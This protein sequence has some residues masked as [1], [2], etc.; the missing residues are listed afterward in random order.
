MNSPVN[1]IVAHR[2][3]V[4]DD[5]LSQYIKCGGEYEKLEK[6][7][8]EK[9]YKNPDYI[10]WEGHTGYVFLGDTDLYVSRYNYTTESEQPYL[11]IRAE[12]GANPKGGSY[13]YAVIPYADKNTLEEYSK[14]PDVVILENSDKLQAV[15][16]K[17]LGVSGYVFYEKGGFG[18]IEVD[19]GAIIMVKEDENTL[20]FSICDATHEKEELVARIKSPVKLTSKDNAVSVTEIDGYTEIK[21]NCQGA[22]GAPFRVKF[23]K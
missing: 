20:E 14:D 12:H 11:E 7:E 21:V 3:I 22:M 10:L 1:T 2:R 17:K 9:R 16:E 4:K 15:S 5:E 13:A 19:T 23:S 6:A 8:F 18:N